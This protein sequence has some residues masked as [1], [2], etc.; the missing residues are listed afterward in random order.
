M[1]DKEPCFYGG[2]SVEGTDGSGAEAAGVGTCYLQGRGQVGSLPAGGCPPFSGESWTCTSFAIA[3]P[4]PVAVPVLWRL[5]ASRCS[6]PTAPWLYMGWGRGPLRALLSSN[7]AC[8]LALLGT[9]ISVTSSLLEECFLLIPF[10]WEVKGTLTFFT[11]GR[12]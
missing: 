2:I 3:V 8:H 12:E 10:I 5:S 9:Y 11:G 7:R 4:R 1:G 6:R